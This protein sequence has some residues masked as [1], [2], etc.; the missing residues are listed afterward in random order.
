[1]APIAVTEP[2]KAH[3]RTTFSSSTLGKESDENKAGGAMGRTK[4]GRPLK[5]RSYPKFETLEE[6]RRYRQEHLAAAYRIFGE[7]GFDEGVA[8]HIS[9]RDPIVS[10][11]SIA[12]RVEKHVVH[13]C[14]L[15]LSAHL[16]RIS[17]RH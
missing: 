14:Y 9:V 16:I 12:G 7:R 17:D 4:D 15:A 11:K 2:S 5:I 6:E 1:M 13:M 8:G 10:L 3:A